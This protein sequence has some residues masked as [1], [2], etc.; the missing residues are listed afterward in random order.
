MQVSTAMV[1][2]EEGDSFDVIVIVLDWIGF[3]T[4]KKYTCDSFDVNDCVNFVV[5]DCDSI[6]VSDR[7]TSDVSDWDSFDIID[8]D[9]GE[10][11]GGVVL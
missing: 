7:D 10:D 5:N 9:N 2:L 8:C 6:D 4:G 11:G 3:V 1:M